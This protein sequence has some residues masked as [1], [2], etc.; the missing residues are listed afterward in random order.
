MGRQLD[1]LKASLAAVDISAA[2]GGPRTG[3][4]ARRKRPAYVFQ[5]MD[6]R[7]T[8]EDDFRRIQEG[9]GSALA[10]LE[11]GEGRVRRTRSQRSRISAGQGSSSIAVDLGTG[12]SADPDVTMG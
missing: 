3:K 10:T 7:N 12:S 2:A 4:A 6:V 9:V 1:G 8:V 11:P 5:D